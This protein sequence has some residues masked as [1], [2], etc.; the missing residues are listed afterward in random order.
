MTV[1]LWTRLTLVV[2]FILMCAGW[3]IYWSP[4]RI[5][6]AIRGKKNSV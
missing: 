1:L 5:R 3:S 6:E 4:H 2:G